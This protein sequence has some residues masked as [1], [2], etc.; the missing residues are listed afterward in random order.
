MNTEWDVTE[1]I[2]PVSTQQPKKR[3][4]FQ[5]DIQGHANLPWWSKLLSQQ[6]LNVMKNEAVCFEG[7]SEYLPN[8]Q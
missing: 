3:E 7:K 1:N 2:K 4:I 8:N 6:G 5:S